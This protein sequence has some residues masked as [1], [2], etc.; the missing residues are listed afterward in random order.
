[1]KKIFTTLFLASMMLSAHAALGLS[2]VT[3]DENEDETTINITKDTTIV[4]TDYEEAFFSEEIV[5]SLNG[6]V[7]T[8]GQH[9]DVTISRSAA[10]LKDE[11]CLGQCTTGN[12]QLQQ[13]LSLTLTNTVNGWF[14]HFYPIEAG[15]TTTITYTFNDGVNPAIALTVKYSYL[16]SAVEDVVAPQHQGKIYNLLG[17]EM[18]AAELGDLPKGIYIINGKKYIKQ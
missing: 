11:F 4:V 7:S 1:M 17:Q 6:S 15:T 5:M 18:P 12:G 16:T 2:I 10:G 13:D 14:A 9:L 8:A 3:V